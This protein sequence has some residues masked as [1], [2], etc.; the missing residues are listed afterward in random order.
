MFSQV[1][2]LFSIGG[3]YYTGEPITYTY[4]EDK[5]FETS[6]NITIKL[7]H[8]VGK[9]VKLRLHFSD[10]WIMVSEVTFDSGKT[11]NRITRYVYV[12][13]FKK[14]SLILSFSQFLITIVIYK[15]IWIRHHNYQIIFYLWLY[16]FI[17]YFYKLLINITDKNREKLNFLLKTFFIHKM[18]NYYIYLSQPL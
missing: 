10:R 5:I 4:M 7:H 16:I 1:D 6:R 2:I 12:F 11:I 9:F 8:R 14:K 13:L 17:L 18:E 15:C 3:K